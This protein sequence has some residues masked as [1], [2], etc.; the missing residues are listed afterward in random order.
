[1]KPIR[2]L[3]NPTPGLDDYLAAKNPGEGWQEFR[4]HQ[5]GQ[6]Y[7]ELAEALDNLQHGLCGYCEIDLIDGDRQVEHVIPQSDP[8]CGDAKSMD[9]A[10]M[11]ACCTG[12]TQKN[13]FG[14]DAR[15]DKERYLNASKSS[16]GEAKG[17]ASDP[18]FVDPRTLPALPSLTNVQPDGLIEVNENACEAHGVSASDMEKTINRLRLNTERL[19]LA[20]E[21]RWEALSDTWSRHFD[22]PATMDLA[23]R[24]ELL[25][26]EKGCLPRFFTTNRTY[27]GGYGEKILGEKPHKW[28]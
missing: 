16:C 19:R 8:G 10:N 14:P 25:P 15:G 24:A 28:I 20:R 22:N 11:I 27:F 1:M 9:P 2:T 17:S 3:C 21:R 5:G 4:S 18:T 7:R 13:I 6:A 23:A 12:G 26:D